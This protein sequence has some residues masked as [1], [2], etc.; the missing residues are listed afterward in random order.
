MYSV[1]PS[2]VQLLY[3]N[4]VKYASDLLMI[5]LQMF[6]NFKETLFFKKFLYIYCIAEHRLCL[7]H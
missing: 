7:F 4:I 5:T 1:W 2:C 6:T 3:Y